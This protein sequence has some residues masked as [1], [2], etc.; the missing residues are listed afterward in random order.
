MNTKKLH[1]T[2]DRILARLAPSLKGEQIIGGI[3]VP[4]AVRRL[5]EQKA[6]VELLIVSAGP[7]CKIAKPGR[8]ALVAKAVCQPIEYDGAEYMVFSEVTAIAIIE[9]M[10]GEKTKDVI[11]APPPPTI[12]EIRTALGIPEKPTDDS[13]ALPS[14]P[15]QS[16]TPEAVV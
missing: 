15:A 1:A 10:D 13:S 16:K 7:D 14:E 2:C 11:M 6:I 5:N 9:E 4:E 12:A 3:V 8:Y